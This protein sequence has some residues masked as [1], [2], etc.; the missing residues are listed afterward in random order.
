MFSFTIE[1]STLATTQPW[2]YGVD[3]WSSFE[4]YPE[5]TG[6]TFYVFKGIAYHQ[7]DYWSGTMVAVKTFRNKHGTV[8]DWTLYKTRSNLGRKIAA[9]FNSHLESISCNG[10]LS[11][12]KPIEAAMESISDVMR[13]TRFLMRYDKRFTDSEV[14]LFEDL[15]EGDF[16]T[17]VNSQGFT[18]GVGP[19]LLD[20]FCH[21]SFHLS[22]GYLVVCNLKGIENEGEFILTNPTIHSLDGRF[23]D[24]DRRDVGIFDFFQNHICNAVCENLMTPGTVTGNV[25][26]AL[27]FSTIDNTQSK[28]VEAEGETTLRDNLNEI[29]LPKYT[30]VDLHGPPPY[31]TC[32]E[33]K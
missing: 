12:V 19:E 32:M 7:K 16:N 8:D 25:P 3:Y 33:K 27:L 17:F 13:I 30:S 10:R 26:R 22:C 11:F 6:K 2:K 1:N 21:F 9:S 4:L 15:L 18:T 5:W 20:A 14:V 28:A 29:S 24:K 23:G 31:N